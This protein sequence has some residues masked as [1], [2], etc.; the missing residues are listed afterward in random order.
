MLAHRRTLATT[1]GLVTALLGS[2]CDLIDAFEDEG[3]T[4]VQVFTTHHATS[5]DGQM[6]VLG[7]DGEQ[8]VF[9]SDEGWTITLT[10]GY[11]VTSGVT[12]IGCDGATRELDLYWGALAEDLN[13]EDLELASVGSVQSGP[14]EYCGMTVHYGPFD[15]E[16][17]DVEPR[18]AEVDG[19][20]IFLAGAAERDGEIVPFQIRATGSLDVDLDLNAE[21]GQPLRITGNE[22]FPVELTLSKTYD[23]FFDGIDFSAMGELDMATQTLAVLELETRVDPGTVVRAR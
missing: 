12:L 2:G 22:N 21:L 5:E 4:Q 23:R 17:S 7:G 6:P 11:V 10:E 3:K 13:V 14:G 8:R 20:T 18:S 15:A 19:A 1:L 9:Q 16:T